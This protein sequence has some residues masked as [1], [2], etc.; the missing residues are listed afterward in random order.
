MQRFMHYVDKTRQEE[1]GRE[2]QLEDFINDEVETQW[3][4]KDAKKR[5]EK[6]VRQKHLNHVLKTREEQ[7]RDRGK[8]FYYLLDH[9]LF[10]SEFD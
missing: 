7:I 8:S 5:K 4:K 1:Q 9:V 3:K 10:Q 2:K 6:E